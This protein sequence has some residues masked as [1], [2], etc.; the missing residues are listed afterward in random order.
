MAKIYLLAAVCLF[1][2]SCTDPEKEEIKSP[3]IKDEINITC[4]GK[5]SIC[6]QE[7]A[8][9]FCQA[10]IADNQQT[11]KHYGW[12]SNRCKALQYLYQN[13]CQ[14]GYT[15]KVAGTIDCRPSASKNNCPP[16]KSDCPE[17]ANN[18]TTCMAKKYNDQDLPQSFDL[19]GT[20]SGK[21]QAEYDL[22]WKA[23]IRNLD[24]KAL[25]DISCQPTEKKSP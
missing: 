15:G 8:P 5:L 14:K 7:Y 21:C 16:K 18:P 4:T 17:T 13:L 2:T 1:F 12:G 19:K 25:N 9:S 24:P 23:C 11:K 6:T 20:G 3:V 22:K 10:Q